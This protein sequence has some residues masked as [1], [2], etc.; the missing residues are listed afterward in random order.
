MLEHAEKNDFFEVVR[1]CGVFF[2]QAQNAQ[3]V[4]RECWIVR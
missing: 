1:S 4:S 3:A 2:G